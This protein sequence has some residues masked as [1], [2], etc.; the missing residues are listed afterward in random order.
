MKTLILLEVEH[1]KPIESLWDLVAGRAYTIDGVS[2]VVQ[3]E[4]SKALA[5]LEAVKE[6]KSLR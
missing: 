4:P 5:T 2:N 3:P 6:L 1:T